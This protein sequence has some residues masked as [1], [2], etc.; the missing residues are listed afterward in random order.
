MCHA[1]GEDQ[2]RCTLGLGN[3]SLSSK[4]QLGSS[5]YG[6]GGAG[7]GLREKALRKGQVPVAEPW[8]PRGFMAASN[9]GFVRYLGQWL[10]G[11][12]ACPLNS[13]WRL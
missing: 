6:N 12:R 5:S 8:P 3:P 1:G 11:E 7:R 9:A 4:T 10:G 13:S 2:P